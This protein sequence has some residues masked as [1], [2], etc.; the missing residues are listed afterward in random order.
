MLEEKS[1]GL[2][3]ITAK[4][5]PGH[6]IASGKK[7]DHRFPNGTISMQMP[8]FESEGFSGKPFHRGTLNLDVSPYSFILG[9]PSYQF[10]QVK[11]CEYLP[12]ENFSFFPCRLID[13]LDDNRKEYPSYV[14]WPHPSTKPGFE[15]PPC[16]LELLAP[17]IPSVQ[18]G[19]S[20]FI[21]SIPEIIRFA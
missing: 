5:V 19:Q 17:Y 1:P 20:L 16:V 9:I 14:Y 12:P 3:K 8:F 11:W 13:P 2:T 7:E 15:Q 21:K 4:I 18:Y 6:G 10:S